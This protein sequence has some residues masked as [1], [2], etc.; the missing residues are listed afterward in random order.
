MH[1][2]KNCIPHAEADLLMT[3]P[4]LYYGACSKGIC[5]IYKA[6]SGGR[7]PEER[8]LRKMIIRGDRDFFFSDLRVPFTLLVTDSFPTASC[9]LLHRFPVQ[10]L[11]PTCTAP[12]VPSLTQEDTQARAKSD[13]LKHPFII[14]INN[15][16]SSSSGSY[17][18]DVFI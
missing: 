15:S 1:S 2:L 6:E 9:E 3:A 18:P 7:L 5:V 12:V 10:E 8:G 14:I 17:V 13:E 11:C 4:R 16:S